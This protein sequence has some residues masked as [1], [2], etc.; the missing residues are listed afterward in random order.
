[1]SG[2]SVA[3]VG[4]IPGAKSRG[5]LAE[6]FLKS[7]WLNDPSIPILLGS[8]NQRPPQVLDRGPTG[9]LRH[10]DTLDFRGA[11]ALETPTLYIGNGKPIFLRGRALARPGLTPFRLGPY[12][13]SADGVGSR[14]GDVFQDGGLVVVR[15]FLR[16]KLGFLG[17]LAAK[18]MTWH[19]PPWATL[20]V[21]YAFDTRNLGV[22]VSFSGTA[23]P[24]QRR[25]VDWKLESDHDIE[26]ELSGA[27]YHEFVEAGDCQDALAFRYSIDCPVKNSL[28]PTEMT[29]EELRRIGSTGKGERR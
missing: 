23:V 17:Q 14:C 19:W 11:I 22:A 4:W 10:L 9:L 26:T 3:L 29:I 6:G 16:M 15:I 1:M 28:L 5:H 27:G 18:A 20:M 7:E 13:Y 25:Y 21:E 2:E 24:S 12:Q 8:G